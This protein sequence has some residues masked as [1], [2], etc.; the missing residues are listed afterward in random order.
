ML[1]S[2]PENIPSALPF[3]YLIITSEWHKEITSVLQNAAFD[4]LVNNG[5]LPEKIH[6]ITVPGSFELTAAAALHADLHLYDAI[7]CL[8]C[9]VQGETRHFEFICNAVASGLTNI[10]I[11]QKIPVI[12]GVL[13]TDTLQQ[14]HERAGGSHGNKGIEAAIAAIKMA[15]VKRSAGSL[16]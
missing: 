16:Q 11:K 10:S 7:I 9:V 8:G 12:F 1:T 3:S 6:Q 14:A 15:E 5:A 4:T 13:T 2:T